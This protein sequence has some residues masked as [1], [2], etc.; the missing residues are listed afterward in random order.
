MPTHLGS[1][2]VALLAG[3]RGVRFWPLSRR[4]R[5]KQLLDVTGE[6]PLLRLSR[7]R[8]EGLCPPGNVL[9]VTSAD[10][11]EASRRLLGLPARN[12][13]A[14]PEGRN[15]APAVGLALAVAAARDPDAVVLCL[16]ADHHVANPRRLRTLLGKAAGAARKLQAPV[17]LGITPRGPSTDFGYVVP[18][19]EVDV[20]GARGLRRVHHFAE[21]PTP[22]RAKA[23]LDRRA[24]WN[25]GMF[26]LP[27][28]ATVEAMSHLVPEVTRALA[29]LP[30]AKGGA[31]LTRA[32][33]D[34]WPSLPSAS[35]DVAVLERCANAV[36]LEAG[37]LGW[38]DVGSWD[39]LGAMLPKDD[40][41]NR[42]KGPSFFLRSKGCMTFQ[43]DSSRTLVVLGAQDLVLID[44]GDVILAAPRAELGRLRELVA[45]LDRDRPEMT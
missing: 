31:A 10:I 13:L 2:F 15:T 34:C 36:V 11:A 23:L 14:E 21:K 35:F 32:L 3:G 20:P 28:R 38:S 6:G 18:G 30:L 42:S 26:V 1:T 24:L 9:L 45:V 41:G 25:S 5:P 8:V 29:T 12:V 37:E 19:A 33:Q 4:L 22:Q 27:A 43:H 17:L 7:D 39:A 40:A 16:P 44:A